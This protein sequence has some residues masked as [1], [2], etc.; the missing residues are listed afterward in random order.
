M[1]GYNLPARPETEW[2]PAEAYWCEITVGEDPTATPELAL[3]EYPTL[4][5]RLQNKMGTTPL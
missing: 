2:Y 1:P 3:G 4:A 5:E